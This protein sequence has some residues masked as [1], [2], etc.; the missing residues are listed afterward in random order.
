MDKI[1]VGR[2]LNYSDRSVKLLSMSYS[3]QT[4]PDFATLRQRARE[5]PIEFLRWS[6]SDA[7][8]AAL[9]ADELEK[10]GCRVSKTGGYYRDEATVSRAEISRR[11]SFSSKSVC[12]LCGKP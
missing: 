5:M 7:S 4:T 11:Q 10:A 3:T 1:N 9:A 2:R 12:L 8:R 6:A